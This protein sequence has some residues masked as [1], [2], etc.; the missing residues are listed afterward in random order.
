MSKYGKILDSFSN[1]NRLSIYEA[2]AE[3]FEN[4]MVKKI[5][6]QNGHTL[7]ACR[8]SSMG[9]LDFRYLVVV[10]PN[11]IAEK[12]ECPLS[13]LHW[14]SI[15]TRIS[16]TDYRLK[17][18]SYVPRRLLSLNKSIKRIQTQN[19][20][21]YIYSVEDLP[22]RVQLL[23]QKNTVYQNDGTLIRAL[24]TFQTIVMF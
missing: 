19:D 14:E 13:D 2:F 8:F 9:A 18:Q 5:K 10:V 6:E 15:Q 1:P 16:T 20:Q 24:E 11:S 22:I 23:P 12:D 17:S 7:Y 4:P 21:E 3:Y